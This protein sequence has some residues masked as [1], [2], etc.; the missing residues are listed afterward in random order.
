MALVVAAAGARHALTRQ[1][2]ALGLPCATPEFI[3]GLLM[4]REPQQ[5]A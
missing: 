5:L 1:A 2:E 4:E 3:F